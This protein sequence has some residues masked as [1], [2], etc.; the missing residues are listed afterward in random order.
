MTSSNEIIYTVDEIANYLKVDGFSVR[1]WITEGKL[2]AFKLG[3]GAKAHW[4]V[5]ESDLN[6]F[7]ESR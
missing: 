2:K 4:R 7:M 6:K 3:K 1:R 5:K